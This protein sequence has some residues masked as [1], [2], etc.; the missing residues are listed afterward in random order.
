ME[1]SAIRFEDVWRSFGSFEALAGL[2]FSVPQG[3]ITA[4][5]GRNGAGKTTA[6]KCLLGLLRVDRGRMQILGRRS[7]D[8]RLLEDVGYLS[9]RQMLDDR[10]TVGELVEFNRAFYDSWDL[11]LEDDL[12]RR[13]CLRREAVIAALSRGQ[14][15]KVGLL[16]A[17][18]AR[19]KVLV[20]DEPAANL[21]AVVRREFLETVLDLYR[22][23]GMTVLISTHLLSDVERMADNVVF[24]ED[25]QC[26]LSSNLDDLKERVKAVRL[27]PRNGSA[28]PDV[29]PP[30]LLRSK[31]LGRELLLTLEDCDS[32][33]LHSLG[34]ECHA[35][36]EVRDLPLEDIFLAYATT[37]TQEVIG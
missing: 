28:V 16:L 37:D 4:L 13:L 21:D 1:R 22:T 27:V 24:V 14:A 12:M 35:T 20:L 11:A 26:T 33:L 8:P 15:R 7:G 3:T 5:L 31:R 19:P 17:L 34:E 9:E 18:A 6:L 2:S 32:A 36:V 25:G 29:R 10:L 23:E 30:G